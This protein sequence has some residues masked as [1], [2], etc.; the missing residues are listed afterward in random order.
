[1]RRGL[2]VVVSGL[3][4]LAGYSPLSGVEFVPL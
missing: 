2:A 1:M 4:S 3:A